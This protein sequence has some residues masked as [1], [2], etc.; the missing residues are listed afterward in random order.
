MEELV[1][2]LID[3]TIR[4]FLPEVVVARRWERV[5]ARSRHLMRIRRLWSAMGNYLKMV[6]ARGLE[7]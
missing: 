2:G 7:D 3:D 5:V 4:G 6:K 1:E